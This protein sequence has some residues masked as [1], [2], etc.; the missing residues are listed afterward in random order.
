VLPK[1]ALYPLFENRSRKGRR[2]YSR[3][4]IPVAAFRS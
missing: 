4:G 3:N 1:A 2:A